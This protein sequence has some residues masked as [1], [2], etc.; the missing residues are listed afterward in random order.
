MTVVRRHLA[1]NWACLARAEATSEGRSEKALVMLYGLI[2]PLR[3]YAAFAGRA[4]RREF[5]VFAGFFAACTLLARYADDADGERTAVAAGMGMIELI[6]FLALLLPFVSVGARRLH[7]TGRSGWWL[8]VFYIPYLGFV[9]A[10]GDEAATL[11]AAG[12]FVI[13]F[14]VLVILLLLPGMASEN[15]FGPN[16]RAL[17]NRGA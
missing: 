7:D 14:F 17:P 5:W 6:I 9:A 11:V 12:A 13:G 1:P 10:S 4:T 8:L 3:N 15:G 16:P 2:N